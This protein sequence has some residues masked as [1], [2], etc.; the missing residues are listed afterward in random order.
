MEVKTL[1]SPQELMAKKKALNPL[2]IIDTRAPEDYALEHIPEAINIREIFT[3]LLDSS[4]PEALA[5]LQQDFVRLLGAAGLSG[6]E[7]AIIYEDALNKGYGQSCRGYFLLEYLGY[8]K[9]SIL[10]GGYQAWKQANLPITTE[11]ATTTLRRFPLQVNDRV[12]VTKEQMFKSLDDPNIV[13]L[14]VRD[15]DEWIAESSSPYGKDFCPRKGRIPG[16]VWIEW[17]RMMKSDSEIPMF[18]PKE[19]ILAICEEVDIKPDQTV[20]VYCFKGSRAANTMVA[21]KEAGFKDVRNYYSSWNDWSRDPAMPIE[22][23]SPDPKRMAAR[24]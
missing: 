6:G 19:E 7:T 21:L 14:D 15:Y 22:T 11:V 12:M 9:I 24:A 10:H 17:Y 13:K 2:V 18:R 16:A 5:K 8:P 3:Y 4:S 20:Y 23:G 1:I